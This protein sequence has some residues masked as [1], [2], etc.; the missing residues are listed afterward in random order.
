MVDDPVRI[1]PVA[2]RACLTRSSW[3]ESVPLETFMRAIARSPG[4]AL[5]C[6]GRTQRAQAPCRRNGWT[7]HPY[8]E[9]MITRNNPDLYR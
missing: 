1:D 9:R 6:G 3:A 2:A 8:P 7:Q 5:F 4:A